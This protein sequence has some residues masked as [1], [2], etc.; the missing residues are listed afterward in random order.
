MQERRQ[1]FFLVVLE[2]VHARPRRRHE[3][4]RERH[5]AERDEP[6]EVLPGGSC[7]EQQRERDH[8]VHHPRAEVRLDDHE[9]RRDQR[10]EHHLHRRLAI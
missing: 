9:H 10:A 3:H 2:H 8:H 6:T 7:D 5:D 1:A 4:E